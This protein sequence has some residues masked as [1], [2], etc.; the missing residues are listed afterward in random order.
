V[1]KNRSTVVW[2]WI[3][4]KR[5]KGSHVNPRCAFNREFIVRPMR[6]FA[7]ITGRPSTNPGPLLWL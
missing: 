7:I 4:F 2:F 1:A 3:P 5:F 6:S